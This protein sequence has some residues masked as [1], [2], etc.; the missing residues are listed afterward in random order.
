MVTPSIKVRSSQ[1][2]HDMTWQLR[3]ENDKDIFKLELEERTFK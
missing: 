2:E 3:E 1:G